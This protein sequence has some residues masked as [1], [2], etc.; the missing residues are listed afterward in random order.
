MPDITRKMGYGSFRG[1]SGVLQEVAV[2]ENGN[3]S[4]NKEG[5]AEGV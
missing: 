2:R 3:Q 4:V 1:L 5:R